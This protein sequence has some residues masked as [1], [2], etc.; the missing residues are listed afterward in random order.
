MCN[1]LLHL[2]LEWLAVIFDRFR[3]DV[4]AG[5][6]HV[7]VL[8]DLGQGDA[9]AVAGDVGV[10]ERGALTPALARGERE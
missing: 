4:A 6:K 7:A 10:G 8:G 2:F 1:E 9:A 5:G 3:A